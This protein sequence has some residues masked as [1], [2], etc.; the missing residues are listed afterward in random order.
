ML[1]S[2]WVG[3]RISAFGQCQKDVYA[4][5][6]T[7]SKGKNEGFIHQ[8]ITSHRLLIPRKFRGALFPLKGGEVLETV[9]WSLPGEG[10]A[11][12]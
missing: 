6:T 3:T 10:G 2:W 4:M 7:W 1:G 11:R 5:T 8:G 12:K 9:F